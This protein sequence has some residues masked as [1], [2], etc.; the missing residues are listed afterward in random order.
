MEK[1]TLLLLFSI[2]QMSISQLKTKNIWKNAQ[3]SCKS[4]LCLSQLEFSKGNL[5]YVTHITPFKALILFKMLLLC[6]LGIQ[7]ADYLSN[8]NN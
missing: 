2:S 3:T 5:I 8:L 6:C 1:Q 4:K 7:L